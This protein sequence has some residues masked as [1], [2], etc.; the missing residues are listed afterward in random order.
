MLDDP[1]VVVRDAALCTQA[2]SFGKGFL[3]RDKRWAYIQYGEPQ[4]KAIELFDMKKDPKQYTNQANNPEYAPVV[5]DMKKRMAA[6]LAE[7]RINDLG[8]TY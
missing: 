4:T 5:A 3:L 1:T 2:N 8:K 6:K 7:L